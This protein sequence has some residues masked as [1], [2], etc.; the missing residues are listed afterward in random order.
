MGAWRTGVEMDGAGR[1][2]NGTGR[3]RM[4]QEG[5]TRIKRPF[6]QRPNAPDCKVEGG[7]G[8]RV[9]CGG[10]EQGLSSPTGGCLH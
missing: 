5:H 1:E 10:E 9:L 4:R 3:N 8:K 6:R 2:G 7:E